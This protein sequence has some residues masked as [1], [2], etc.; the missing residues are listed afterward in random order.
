[1]Q[2]T[3]LKSA[4]AQPLQS[5]TIYNGAILFLPMA[6]I[7]KELIVADVKNSGRYHAAGQFFINTNKTMG[8][9]Q[10]FPKGM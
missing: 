8:C 9:W 4:L 3:L 6:K 2:I 1:M 10:I 5:I 7:L